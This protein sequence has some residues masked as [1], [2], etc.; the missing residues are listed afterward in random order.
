M[1][2]K[3]QR[4]SPS[5]IG[6]RRNTNNAKGT[7]ATSLS[8]ASEHGHAAI[9]RSSSSSS[10]SA[11]ATTMG[12]AAGGGLSRKISLNARAT[13][14]SSLIK[15]TSSFDSNATTADSSSSSSLSS[16]T[17]ENENET[18]SCQQRKRTAQ[19]ATSQELLEQVVGEVPNRKELTPEDYEAMW[20]S[21]DEFRRMKKED[22]IPT[23]KK[24]AKRIPLDFENL[25]EEP[26]G[27]EHKTP[28][29]SRDREN[30]RDDAMDAVLDEQERQWNVNAVPNVDNIAKKYRQHSAHCQMNAY[31]LAQKDA[32]WVQEH[33]VVDINKGVDDKGIH[34]VDEES[35]DETSKVEESAMAAANE[36]DAT[37]EPVTTAEGSE[38]KEAETITLAEN[39][40]SQSSSSL[41]SS[42]LVLSPSSTVRRSNKK[43][44]CIRSQQQQPGVNFCLFASTLS[45]IPTMISS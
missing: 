35:N 36:T 18:Q 4:S 9:V 16:P 23:V 1:V 11:A 28:R 22:I 45:V 2:S 33:V 26:R 24:M 7:K 31:L 34:T 12:G 20:Y 27:L 38:T 19:F 10:S 32:E 8:S 15:M 17:N 43:L 13:P 5:T 30:N 37:I 3:V 44:S 40:T 25:G 42:S 6:T 39:K 41:S 29:G 14:T 21:K